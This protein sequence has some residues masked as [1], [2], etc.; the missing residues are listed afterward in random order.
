[1][2][3]TLLKIA[4]IA[5]GLALCMGCSSSK[6]ETTPISD[7]GQDGAGGDAGADADV[8]G[9]ADGD[10]DGGGDADGDADAGNDGG[11]GDPALAAIIGE[12]CTVA[13]TDA[14]ADPGTCKDLPGYKDSMKVFC[15]S[16]ADTAGKGFCTIADCKT[17]YTNDAGVDTCPA[18]ADHKN[19]CSDIS[20]IT[21]DTSDD[22][23]GNYICTR[24]C[25]LTDKNST[26]NPCPDGFA[27]NPY[28]GVGSNHEMVPTC[29]MPA[30]AVAAD[31]GLNT[32][33][34][35]NPQN[36]DAD[37]NTG[38]G[39]TCENTDTTDLTVGKC[40]KPGVC[41]PNGVCGN[42][43]GSKKVGDPCVAD[44]ECPLDGMCMS[45]FT[46]STS[47]KLQARNG[48]CT[49]A[50]CLAALDWL[51]CPDGSTCN[52]AYS[53]G[54][55]CE[56]I[57]DSADGTT[58]RQKSWGAS[59]VL[60]KN[61]DYECYLLGALGFMIDGVQVK[62]ADKPV[63][64]LV[65]QFSCQMMIDMSSPTSQAKCK[66]LALTTSEMYCRDESGTSF[67]T[68]YTQP[69][70]YCMDKTTSGPTGAW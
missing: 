3:K 46:D 50:G 4:C 29:V 32:G 36:G 22:A 23:N 57:C 30:C 63:C 51:K 14:G 27:C 9:D 26:T 17:R 31:C 11:T 5:L 69:N 16:W 58:C 28:W 20:P 67:E 15:F 38:A 65:Y 61:A 6:K 2:K 55:I 59:T 37:C 40:F 68:D 47:G 45:E 24:R 49:K 62:I 52:R 56:L 42:P 70:T 19:I 54:G 41:Y 7:G 10:G 53:M 1:M 44:D 60:D 21:S 33:V 18:D 39:E 8:D 34:D 12:A 48:Y 13:Q 35:C 64:D 25:E 43:G 66:M